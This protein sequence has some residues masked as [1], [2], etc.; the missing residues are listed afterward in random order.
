MQ[1]STISIALVAAT[2]TTPEIVNGIIEVESDPS[3]A[4]VF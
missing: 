3:N 1:N 4:A 2:T